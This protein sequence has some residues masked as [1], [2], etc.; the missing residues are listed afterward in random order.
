MRLLCPARP[1]WVWQMT[2]D[3]E[4][5]DFLEDLE[6]DAE[7]LAHRERVGDLLDRGHSEY[8]QVPL[9]ARLM[10]S[11][12][13]EVVI[14]VPGTGSL[15]GELVRV[16]PDWCALERGGVRWVIALAAVTVVRGASAKA[17]PEVAWGPADRLGIRSA[18]RRLV[19]S[20]QSSVV[21]LRDGARIEA[22]LRRVGADFVE[23]TT[24]NG[25]RLLLASCHLAALRHDA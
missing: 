13:R 17:L 2:D 6:A 12:G 16:G 18:L 1:D 8:H 21:H 14:D 7:T 4:L 10:A 19:D 24:P 22:V 20:G 5:F 11:K 9:A 25:E 23:V 15:R 3:A